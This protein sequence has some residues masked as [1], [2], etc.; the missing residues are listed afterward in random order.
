MQ[1]LGDYIDQIRGVS[2]KPADVRDENAGIAILR[3]NNIQDKV[4]LSDLVY[5]DENK[6]SDV[7]FLKKGDVLICASSGSKN[8]VG[9][10]VLIP[11]DMNA[12]F[13]A[14][15]KVVRIKQISQ[16]NSDFIRMFFLSK[17]YRN[18]IAECSIGAN[19]N[20]IKSDHLNGL[21][22]NIPNYDIQCS[23]V[24][25]L[26]KLKQ[27]IDLKRKQLED[28]D[29]LVKSKFQ[30]MFG[31]PVENE[32]ELP[33]KRFIDVVKMQRGFDLP[34]HS[35]DE[36]GE[37]PVYGSN[38]I[39]GY[40]SESKIDCGVITGRSGT[41]GEVYYCD[42]PFWPLNT[43]LFSVDRHGNNVVYLRYLLE[44]FDLKRFAS[45]VGVPTLNRNDFH[46]IQI[47]DVPHTEQEEFALFVRKTEK[48]KVLLKQEISDLEELMD[49]KMDEY[50][51]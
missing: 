15:C 22:I 30:E 42:T 9:K 10:A 36:K 37:I 31:D 40:H 43:T 35:R 8:L 14:F 21:G 48:A 28:L 6:V 16:V 4:D 23:A 33:T 3:A 38:G 51:G 41:I 27:A 50:F 1:R 44:F 26:T 46:E 7:Q 2:Y 49:S 19:I 47:I 18:A 25:Y 11:N 24:D 29:E 45:G 13:G 20:N 12:S 34:V 17:N 39:L 32:K 5:V